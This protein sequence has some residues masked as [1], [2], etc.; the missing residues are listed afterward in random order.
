MCRA[1]KF[2]ANFIMM[3]HLVPLHE[4][5]NFEE[6]VRFLAKNFPIVKLDELVARTQSKT[7]VQKKGVVVFTFDPEFSLPG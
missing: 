6:T 2:G 4:S 3:F 7:R 5:A 1:R